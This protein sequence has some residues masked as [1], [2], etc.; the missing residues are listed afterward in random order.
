MKLTYKHTKYACYIGY[1]TQAI[2]NNL[3]PLLFLTFHNQF[4]ISLAAISGLISINFCVQILVDFVSVKF[5]DRLGYRICSIAAFVLS[6]IGLTALGI[7]PNIMS[8]AYVGLV[9][10]TVINAIG[11]GLLEVLVSPIIEALP[12]DEKDSAMS[13]LH[14]FYC[15]GHVGVVLISTLY[16]NV[17]G[18]S[19][20]MYLPVIW[21]VVPLLDLVL[22][23]KVPLCKLVEDDE[24]IPLRKVFTMKIFWLLLLLMI[25]AGASE[26]AM[27]QWSSL[28]AEMGLG[29]SKTM[30][31]LLGPCAFAVCMGTARAIYGKWGY[32]M[33]LKKFIVGSSILCIISY[34]IT[35]FAPN[36]VLSLMGCAVCGFSVGIMWP[37][38]FSLAGEYC[39]A[40]GT[41][42]YALL[43]LG[44]DVGCSSGPSL[45]GLISG[46]TEKGGMDSLLQLTG[47]PLKTGMLFAIVFPVA[48]AMGIAALRKR[49]A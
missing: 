39:R 30:G 3:A 20:W 48:M 1:I 47:S 21:A 36:P 43:A 25:C 40:G 35:V 33:D 24:L 45:V 37:G 46:S 19:N 16:F 23:T 17:F 41:A 13:L 27:S 22:F 10:A 28:F 14:S 8:N 9:I 29:V 34:L 42:M 2:I 44:G 7:L 12:G 15:W 6:A 38:V 11:G 26:Q 18:I 31:D 5:V 4:G 49:K 32:R